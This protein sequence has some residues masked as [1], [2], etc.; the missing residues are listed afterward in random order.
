M[1]LRDCLGLPYVVTLYHQGHDVNLIRLWQPYHEFPGLRWLARQKLYFK[2][3]TDPTI[4]QRIADIDSHVGMVDEFIDHARVAQ[5][6]DHRKL[7]PMVVEFG[8]DVPD[9]N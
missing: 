7:P 4:E 5:Q 3:L 2:D 9:I 1:F 8:G 6:E